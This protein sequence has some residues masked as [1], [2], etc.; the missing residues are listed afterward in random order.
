MGK[1]RAKGILEMGAVLTLPAAAVAGL[2]QQ[3]YP[4]CVL[5]LLRE[6]LDAAHAVP[7]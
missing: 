4:D 3:L 5:E 6:S 2:L 1:L 7:R